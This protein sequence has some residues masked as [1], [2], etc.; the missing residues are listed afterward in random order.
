MMMFSIS[1]VTVANNVS[2]CKYD[3]WSLTSRYKEEI[4]NMTIRYQQQKVNMTEF[5]E[6]LEVVA[7]IRHF[8][9]TSKDTYRVAFFNWFCLEMFCVEDG[10][11]PASESGAIQQI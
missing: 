5:R 2:H 4:S 7:R 9:I 1:V 3:H 11:I 6:S 10:K 8:I